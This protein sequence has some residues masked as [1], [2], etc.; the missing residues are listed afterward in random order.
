LIIALSIGLSA[1]A[2]LAQQPGGGD[3]QADLGTDPRT[4]PSAPELRSLPSAIFDEQRK[5]ISAGTWDNHDSLEVI[6]LAL[7]ADGDGQPELIRYLEVESTYLLRQEEDRNLD[8]RLDATSTFERG[9]LTLRT[10]DDDDDGQSDSWEEY[11]NGRLHRREVDRD[12]DGVRDAFYD[13][14]GHFLVLEQHD[15]DNDSRIDRKV[16]YEN[17][18]RTT[19]SE[20]LDRDGR[21]DVWY[22]FSV[23]GGVE[24]VTR[25]ERDKQGHGRPDVFETFVPDGDRAQLAKREE[26]VDGDG[27]ADIVSIYRD[28]K[29]VR[30]ELASPELR[31]L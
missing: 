20:D 19:A 25:I 29:L 31:P 21:P 15:A 28:G 10:L 30:R 4:A 16:R 8:G 12:G 1:A 5:T 24:L 6:E 11:R 3:L 14:D 27:Q 22:R 23:E 13:Y 9:E 18:R 7:D 17:R 26:D 2:I